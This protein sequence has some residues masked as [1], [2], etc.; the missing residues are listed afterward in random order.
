LFNIGDNVVFVDKRYEGVALVV[1][2]VQGERIAVQRKDAHG[3]VWMA[4][5]H[6]SEL[7]AQDATQI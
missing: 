3:K 4:Y 2:A 6:D 5:V 1:S 7:K